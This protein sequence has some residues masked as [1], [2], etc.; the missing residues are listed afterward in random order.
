MEI[1][2]LTEQIIGGAIE[3]HR[4]LGPGLLESAYEECLCQELS[5]RKIEFE[6]QVPLPVTYKGVNLDCGYRIDVLIAKTVVVEI[7]SVEDL[8]PIH[9]AQVM[10]YLKLGGWKIGLLFN[11]NSVLLKNNFK[12]IVLGLK[13]EPFPNKRPLRPLHR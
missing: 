6:R 10:T 13:D 5:L 4:L 9:Q 2:E 1:N 3:V 11:F 12:R 7:K 8:E